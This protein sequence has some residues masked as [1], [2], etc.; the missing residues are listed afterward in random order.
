M[1]SNWYR[2]KG[3][4]LA[5]RISGC[6][7][8]PSH[9]PI[10]DDDKALPTFLR[11]WKGDY[12]TRQVLCDVAMDY[13]VSGCPLPPHL[14][15]FVLVIFCQVGE[16]T[17][18]NPGTDPYKNHSRDV[19][20]ANAVRD[21]IDDGFAATRNPA[22]EKRI[23][24]LHRGGSALPTRHRPLGEKAVEKIWGRW[25]AFMMDDLD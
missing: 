15:E 8:G 22:T 3:G 13:V 5:P 7:S 16:F 4:Q 11:A 17:K 18:K 12:I 14:C 25:A 6:I 24:L 23:G 20:I 2:A 21:V 10:Y 1:G 19:W 9:V